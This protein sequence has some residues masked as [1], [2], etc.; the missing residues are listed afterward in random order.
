MNYDEDREWSDRYITAVGE[1]VG[2][3]LLVPAPVE[4][5]RKEATDL[6]VIKA[7]DM[8]IAARV[9]RSGYAEKYPRQFTLRCGRPSGT[10]TEL[11]KIVDGWADWMF[12]GHASS[13]NDGSISDWMLIDL[14]ALRAAFVRY[15]NI[16]HP[17]YQQGCGMET[18]RDGTTFRYFDVRYLPKSVVMNSSWDVSEREA[19][20]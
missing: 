6:I 17:P 16:L 4:R 2:P 14:T 8:T 12:Y 20:D 15:P 5:D 13:R 18:N 3:Y 10:K 7:R 1:I 19:A 11:S 9:R